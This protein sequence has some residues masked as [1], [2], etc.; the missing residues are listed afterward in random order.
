MSNIHLYPK[1]NRWKT[2]GLHGL[3]GQFFNNTNIDFEFISFYT[4][5][6]LS[7]KVEKLDGSIVDKT[8]IEY[9]E[10][11]LET[12][13]GFMEFSG[14]QNGLWHSEHWRVI[15]INND[16][17]IGEKQMEIFQCWVKTYFQLSIVG[18]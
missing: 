18:A 14:T 8:V 4:Y 7:F 5:N 13:Q 15:Q 17:F 9:I 1:F 11:P 12:K 16:Y 6:I 10:T 2:Y 3:P